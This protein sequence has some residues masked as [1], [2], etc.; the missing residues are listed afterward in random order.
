MKRVILTLATLVLCSTAMAESYVPR[1]GEV[2]FKMLRTTQNEAIHEVRNSPFTKH[3]Y[4]HPSYKII[5]LD[6][7]KPMHDYLGT[8]VSMTDASCW[9]LSQVD[10]ET[11][12]SFFKKVFMKSGLNLSIVRLNCGSSDYATEL[13]NYNDH[14]GDVEMKNFSIA[15]DEKYMIP[16]IKMLKN[17][18]PDI[19]FFSSI[20][21]APGWM[22]IR[23]C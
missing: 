21:S 20:W 18:N 19:Y 12:H 7:A 3:F 4:S 9:L 2:K 14:K 13:Y 22:K 1:E 6:A 16:T 15:R 23:I 8:G 11:R 10:A 5:D 17:Y